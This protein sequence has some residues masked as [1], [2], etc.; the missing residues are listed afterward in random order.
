MAFDLAAWKLITAF[1]DEMLA[2]RA[3]VAGLSDK[4]KEVNGLT[5]ARKVTRS[6]VPTALKAVKTTDGNEAVLAKLVG[7]DERQASGSRC[8]GVS[9][10]SNDTLRVYGHGRV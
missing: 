10:T 6:T 5:T 2:V 9:R 1:V 8:R 3:E 7:I 4:E